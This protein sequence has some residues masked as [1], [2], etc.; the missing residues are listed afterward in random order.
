MQGCKVVVLAPG[1]HK[2]SRTDVACNGLLRM[3]K[4]LD[5]HDQVTSCII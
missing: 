1:G 2:A 3:K 4:R 5:S